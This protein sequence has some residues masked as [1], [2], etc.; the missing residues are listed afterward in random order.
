MKYPHPTMCSRMNY[1]NYCNVRSI[2]ITPT[3]AAAAAGAFKF[4]HVLFLRA[5]SHYYYY[6][7]LLPDGCER[8]CAHET[9][10]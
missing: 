2:K 6:C 1:L 7:S 8:D 10:V 3:A 5:H 4:T 9:A